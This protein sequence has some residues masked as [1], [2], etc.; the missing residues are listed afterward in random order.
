MEN[1]QLINWDRLD[2]LKAEIGEE[3]FAEVVE[4]FL[5][6]FEE[7]LQRLSGAEPVAELANEFHAL[8]G[9]AVNLGMSELAQICA[10]AEAGARDGQMTHDISQISA[11]FHRSRASLAQAQA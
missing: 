11:I 9:C 3:D 2:E 4:L 6:E 5:A 1:A 8:K 7:A 10:A